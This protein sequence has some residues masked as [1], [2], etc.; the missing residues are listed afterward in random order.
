MINKVEDFIINDFSSC[1]AVASLYKKQHQQVQ[2]AAKLRQYCSLPDT[3]RLTNLSL[4]PVISNGKIIYFDPKSLNYVIFYN[5]FLTTDNFRILSIVTGAQHNP[6]VLQ[7]RCILCLS[8][9]IVKLR[10]F[11][12]ISIIAS[13]FFFHRYC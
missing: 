1:K 12:S 13:S 7:K 8:A 3:I 5:Q 11:S 4:L 9:I 2:Y 6:K 10:V